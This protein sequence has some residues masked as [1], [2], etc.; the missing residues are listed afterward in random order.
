MEV[1]TAIVSE[2]KAL[3]NKIAWI[4]WALYCTWK[5]G[6]F[7]YLALRKGEPRWFKSRIKLWK[8]LIV[9]ICLTVGSRSNGQRYTKHIFVTLNS[10]QDFGVGAELKKQNTHTQKKPQ[11]QPVEKSKNHPAAERNC[12]GENM[13]L[14]PW[15][16]LAWITWQGAGGCAEVLAHVSGI[17]L[18]SI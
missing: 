2:Y 17:I 9:S 7:L 14:T 13:W 18:N 15:Q 16:L 8:R 5:G 12:S 10:F 3:W 6:A 4:W 1:E 11:T